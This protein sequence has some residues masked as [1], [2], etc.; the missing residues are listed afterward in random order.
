MRRTRS[1][2]KYYVTFEELVTGERMEFKVSDRMYGMIAEG[3]DGVLVHQ[4][5]RYHGFERNV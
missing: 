5:T 2:T 4:G 1:T 3:D